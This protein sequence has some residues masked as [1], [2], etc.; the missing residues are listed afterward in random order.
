M[1]RPSSKPGP[2]SQLVGAEALSSRV[3]VVKSRAWICTQSMYITEWK[4]LSA[5]RSQA[6]KQINSRFN[7]AGGC[8]FV[9]LSIPPDCSAT[10][11]LTQPQAL[12]H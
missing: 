8:S 10:L 9:I 7:V 1:H 11:V 2:D 6:A 4:L 12:F 3:H 5:H